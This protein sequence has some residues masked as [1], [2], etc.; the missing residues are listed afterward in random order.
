[1]HATVWHCDCQ[2]E[3]PARVKLI[4]KSYTMPETPGT[5]KPRCQEM[6]A[7]NV[8]EGPSH[9]YTYIRL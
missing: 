1:M 3:N 8:R 5:S 4:S 7:A 2:V 6:N 9:T